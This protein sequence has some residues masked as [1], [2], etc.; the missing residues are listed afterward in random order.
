MARRSSLCKDCGKEVTSFLCKEMCTAC[1]E[2]WAQTQWYKEDKLPIAKLCAKIRREQP[3][4]PTMPLL[5]IYADQ[6]VVKIT[7]TV[8]HGLEQVNTAPVYEGKLCDYWQ[9]ALATA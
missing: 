3:K 9:Y 7:R 8:L 1:Y 5:H 6:D 4:A 2:T